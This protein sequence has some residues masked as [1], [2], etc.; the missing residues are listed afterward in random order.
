MASTTKTQM[1]QAKKAKE[2]ANQLANL[3]TEISV[4]RKYPAHV[5]ET[6]RHQSEQVRAAAMQME[7]SYV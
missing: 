7:R 6:F 4:D 1:R 2:L 5:A 3:A